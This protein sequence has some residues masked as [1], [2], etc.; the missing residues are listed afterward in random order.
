M[1]SPVDDLRDLR[2]VFSADATLSAVERAVVAVLILH[3]NGQTGRTDPSVSRIAA[4]T[5][6]GRRTVVRAIAALERAGH[7]G[8]EHRAGIRTRYTVHTRTSARAALVPES[9][10]CHSGTEPVP[11]RHGTS[12][13]AAP[14]R[15]KNEL[16]NGR[17]EIVG[18]LW[19]AFVETMDGAGLKLT[20]KRRQKLGELYAEHLHAEPDPLPL[21]RA[22]LAA[23]RT[24]PFRM[25]TRAYHM[26]ESLFKNAERREA[27]AMDGRARLAGRS[28]NDRSRDPLVMSTEELR[29]WEASR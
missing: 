9:H 16:L 28:T 6:L 5:G 26:P 21:F 15:A 14:E 7:L 19:D 3:R 23:V 29:E 25:E 2:S 10:Q 17:K 11:E 8:G 12:A 24:D 22:I 4:S 27:R 18:R 1:H 20:D 13:T